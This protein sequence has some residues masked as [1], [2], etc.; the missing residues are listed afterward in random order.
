MTA[1]KVAPEFTKLGENVFAAV[2]GDDIIIK[3]RAD[4][5]HDTDPAKKTIRVASTLG[6]KEIDGAEGVI[7]GINAYV[8]RNPR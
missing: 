1:Q 3:I 6:N 7:V 5:R 2:V 4:H 8:Y